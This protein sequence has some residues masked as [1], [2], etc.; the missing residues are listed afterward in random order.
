MKN[1]KN[2]LNFVIIPKKTPFFVRE[3]D[4]IEKNGLHF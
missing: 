2:C 3:P 1:V 4:V